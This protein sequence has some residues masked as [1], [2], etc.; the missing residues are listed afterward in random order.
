MFE[1]GTM[2]KMF[3][4]NLSRPKDVRDVEKPFISL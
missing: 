3:L 1:P 4:P 2:L